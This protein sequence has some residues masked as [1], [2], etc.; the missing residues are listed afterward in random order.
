MDFDDAFG[1]MIVVFT[2]VAV[3]AV[4]VSALFKP[5]FEAKAFNECTG[6]HATYMTALVTE[7][8]VQDCK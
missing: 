6:G 8:R 5:Y 3:V 2:F 7:L 1:L 4:I